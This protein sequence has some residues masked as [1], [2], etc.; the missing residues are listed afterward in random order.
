MLKILKA[1][2]T[3]I[4]QLEIFFETQNTS[5]LIAL[6]DKKIK[7]LALYTTG[8]SLLEEWNINPLALRGVE[9]INTNDAWTRIGFNTISFD[10]EN[11][12]RS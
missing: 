6:K 5:A 8:N 1:L 10:Q 3:E 7:E 2:P 4:P 11:I 12:K 9:W